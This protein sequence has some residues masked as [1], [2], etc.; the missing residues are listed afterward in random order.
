[1]KKEKKTNL[2]FI[3]I[4]KPTLKVNFKETRPYFLYLKVFPKFSH[5]LIILILIWLKE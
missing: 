1:M 4:K 2:F 5:S 3:K